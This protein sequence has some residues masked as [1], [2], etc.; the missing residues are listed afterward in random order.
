MPRR[1]QSD[2][3][4][5]SNLARS[6]SVALTRREARSQTPAILPEASSPQSPAIAM[7]SLPS[8]PDLISRPASPA[9]PPL[10]PT[11]S[12]APAGLDQASMASLISIIDMILDRREA[13][14]ASPAPAQ[15]PPIPPSAPPAPIQA[16]PAP[17]IQT[18]TDSFA[19]AAAPAL[20][21]NIGTFP[22]PFVPPLTSYAAAGTS[23]SLASFFPNVESAVLSA[24]INHEFRPEELY[25]LDPRHRLKQR[26]EVLVRDNG[27]LDLRPAN[28]SLKDYPTPDSLLVPLTRYFQILS[29]HAAPTGQAQMVTFYRDEYLMQIQKF[30]TQYDWHAVKAYHFE[31]FDKRREAMRRGDYSGWA[32]RDQ[33]LQLEY[34]HPNPKQ[35]KSS[36]NSNRKPANS[37]SSTSSQVCYLWNK[38]NCPQSPCKNGRQHVCSSCQSPDHSLDKCAK[39]ST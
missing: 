23:P 39:K 26:P 1:N 22:T 36:P 24:I 4:Q 9:N 14:K 20:Q 8:T 13:A 35:S 30:V 34:L 18:H 33:Q 3:S 17:P 2:T 19:A 6:R 31:F 11:S 37:S 5:T 25:K 38:G 16:I 29:F 27:I 7:T 32:E 12:P 15:P 10:P 21:S 28:G